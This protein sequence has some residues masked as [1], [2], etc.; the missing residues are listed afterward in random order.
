VLK[1]MEAT[2]IE[3]LRMLVRART[4]EIP[5]GSLENWG[6][7]RTG[8]WGRSPPLSALPTELGS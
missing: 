8:C 2:S 7:H 3:A 4:E 5:K 1:C 6:G